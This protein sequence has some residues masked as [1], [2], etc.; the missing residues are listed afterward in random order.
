VLPEFPE[1]QYKYYEVDARPSSLTFQA[2][3]QGLL[4]Y[5]QLQRHEQIMQ[6]KTYPFRYQLVPGAPRKDQ[7]LS[8]KTR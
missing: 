4:D 8:V 5:D 2:V 6:H 1:A 3:L 7:L